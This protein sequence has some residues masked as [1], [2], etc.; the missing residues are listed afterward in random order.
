MVPTAAAPQQAAAAV[1]GLFG[2]WSDLDATVERDL[3]G[4]AAVGGQGSRNRQCMSPKSAR[5]N[6]C[7]L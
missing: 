6:P 3:N 5:M 4:D 2:G 1:E 7:R